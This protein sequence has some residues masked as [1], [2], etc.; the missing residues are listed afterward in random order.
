VVDGTLPTPRCSP[1]RGETTCRGQWTRG[2]KLL[3]RWRDGRRPL[4]GKTV[5]EV[6]ADDTQHRNYD[7]SEKSLAFAQPFKTAE[8]PIDELLRFLC[9]RQANFG[10]GSAEGSVARHRPLDRFYLLASGRLQAKSTPPPPIR[11]YCRSSSS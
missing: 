3:K 10:T 5:N 1:R 4:T 7:V 2:P 6:E 11:T 9:H 8:H